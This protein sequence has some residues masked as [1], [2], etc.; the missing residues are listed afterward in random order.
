M[1]AEK[2]GNVRKEILAKRYLFLDSIDIC[3]RMRTVK[4]WKMVHG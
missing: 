3:D 4:S 2:S 1:P